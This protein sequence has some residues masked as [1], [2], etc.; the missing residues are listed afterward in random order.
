MMLMYKQQ[1]QVHSALLMYLQK[2]NEVKLKKLSPMFRLGVLDQD[3]M[4]KN[5]TKEQYEILIKSYKKLLRFV[6]EDKFHGEETK[7]LKEHAVELSKLINQ[8]KPKSDVKIELQKLDEKGNNEKRDMYLIYLSQYYIYYISVGRAQYSGSTGWFKKTLEKMIINPKVTMGLSPIL[9][10]L[11]PIACILNVI[12]IVCTWYF[13]IV[14]API[15]VPAK[16]VFYILAKSTTDFV[17]YCIR[18]QEMK[19]Y[20]QD[21]EYDEV[22]LTRREMLL[23]GISNQAY[24]RC[25]D[26]LPTFF[27]EA[28]M[29]YSGLTDE[30]KDI[31]KSHHEDFLK[32]QAHEH[33][34]TNYGYCEIIFLIL[35]QLLIDFLV[36]IALPFIGIIAGIM[37]FVFFTVVTFIGPAKAIR[38][39]I[40]S[41]F[42]IEDDKKSISELQQDPQFQQFI[43]Q[44]YKEIKQEDLDQY[45]NSIDDKSV[46][47][48]ISCN[49]TV[50]DAILPITCFV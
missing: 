29:S 26:Y 44:Y 46:S 12:F 18:K 42:N 16:I 23:L 32:K 19:K 45:F 48:L 35:K 15:L 39:F 34:G 38:M 50:S 20:A 14:F 5:T 24:E 33:W 2:N 8:Y 43:T 28:G 6:H 41:E 22:Y 13:M 36:I 40:D 17:N 47:T 11:F 10:V 21:L 9:A 7:E 25:R 27:E 49:D 31:L 4:D 1:L 37:G 30:Q 3:A